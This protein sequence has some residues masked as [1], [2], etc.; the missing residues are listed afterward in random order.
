MRLGRLDMN[1]FDAS[2]CLSLSSP[3]RPLGT[4]GG[5]G[6]WTPTG[7]RGSIMSDGCGASC[8]NAPSL[9][10]SMSRLIAL[11]D[12]TEQELAPV[13]P[14]V[15]IELLVR[16]RR[17]L[18]LARSKGVRVLHVARRP[19]VPPEASTPA[20]IP[21]AI[22]HPALAALPGERTMWLCDVVSSP[23]A[24]FAA[25]SRLI[26]CGARSRCGMNAAAALAPPGSHLSNAVAASSR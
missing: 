21:D 16:V 14:S 2:L 19:K 5:C 18:L 3:T 22:L 15:R 1:S 11:C 6:T 13:D 23:M 7:L 25:A 24:A 20:P 8:R 17:L 10:H 26:V 12:F 4:E 9:K